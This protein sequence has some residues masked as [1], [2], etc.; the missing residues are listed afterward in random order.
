MTVSKTRIFTGNRGAGLLEV[1]LTMAVIAIA[2]P[3][4]YSQIASTNQEIAD[5]AM[6]RAIISGRGAV[7]NFVRLNQDS[8][9]DVAQIQLSDD[10]LDEIAPNAIA[11]FIDKYQVRGATVADVYLVYPGAETDVRTARIAKHIGNDA[12]V[13]DRDGVAYGNTWAAAAPDFEPG[14]LVYRIQRDIEGEDRS[15]YLHRGTSGEDGLNVMMRDLNMGGYNVID[16]GTVDAVSAKVNNVNTTFTDAENITADSV[17]FSDG[18]NMD[19][20]AVAIGNLRVT[21]DI[22]GFRNIYAT[23]L[24]KNG[25]GTDGHIITDRATISNS[26][27]VS[28]NLNLKAS[29]AR[30]VSG[31]TGIHTN[32]VIAPFISAEEIVFFED[33]GLTV[34]GE[35]MMSSSMPLRIGTWTFPSTTPPRFESLTFSNGTIPDAPGRGEF[36]ILMM[37]GWRDYM[38]TGATR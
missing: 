15:K 25:Y 35:L 10:D 23:T 6:A 8:W 16:V 36:G 38:P 4:V 24:N 37:D 14:N 21:G 32:A 27:N 7:L 13:V 9:P 11:G 12:G 29:S 2:T 17:Y 3:F 33:F 22:T 34:S 18:A 1:L 31:F 26:V 20:G 5:I 28:R 19:G 30:T